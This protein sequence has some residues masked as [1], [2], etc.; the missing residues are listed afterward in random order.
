MQRMVTPEESSLMDFTIEL[1]N[2]DREQYK[3]KLS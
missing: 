3:E 1:Q 2:K